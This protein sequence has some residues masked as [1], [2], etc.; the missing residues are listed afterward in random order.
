M[1]LH[2][3]GPGRFRS[4][5]DKAGSARNAQLLNRWGRP[6]VMV[7]AA[8]DVAM[9]VTGGILAPN[10]PHAEAPDGHDC[11]ELAGAVAGGGA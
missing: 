11:R 8:V 5:G 2:S 9:K 7:D 3:Y 1:R 4:R 10:L 6:S